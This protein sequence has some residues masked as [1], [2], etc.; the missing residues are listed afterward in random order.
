MQIYLNT[1]G[2]YL[3]V[4]DEMF[5]IRVPVKDGEPNKQHIAAHKVSSIVMSTSAALSTDAVKLALMNNIDIIFTESD[6]HP[7]GRIW[8]SKLGSTTKI[9]KRQLEASLGK[10]AVTFTKAWISEKMNNQLEFIKDLKKHRSQM[11]DYLDEKINKIENLKVSVSNLQSNKIDDISD[12]IRGL[13]GTAGRL[14]FETINYVLPEQY[15]FEGRSMRPAKD[16]Y[17]AFINY[18]FGILYSRV[19][20]CLMLAGLDPYVGFLHRDDYNQKS[21]VFDFI[22]PYRIFVETAVFRLFSAK[23]VNKA[24]TDEI[25]NGVTLNKEGKE[26]LVTALNDYMESETIRYKGRNQTRANAMQQDAHTF[27]NGLIAREQD[28]D[29]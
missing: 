12:T 13:E 5:E 9:R 8:H 16:A 20:K 10:E 23:K 26:L 14:Y 1:Y 11:A 2:T 6:G 3:H 28:D 19:E 7:I 18:G 4:K 21:M 24:D 15:R 27:A 25:T 17:N 29:S 22:E